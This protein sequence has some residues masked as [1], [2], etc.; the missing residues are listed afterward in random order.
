M[1]GAGGSTLQEQ[2]VLAA[3]RASALDLI[4]VLHNQGVERIVVAAPTTDWLPGDCDVIR[5]NDPPDAPFHFGE[6]LAALIERYELDL[7]TYFGGGSAPLLDASLGE[8]IVG[9]LRGTVDPGSV[10]IPARVVLTNNVHSSDWA[11]ISR[12]RDVLPLIRD[13]R[14]DNSLA[15]LLKE[16]GRYDVRAVSGIRPA[17]SMDIDTPSDLALLARHPALQPRLRQIVNDPRL[18]SIPIDDVLDVMRS[19][20]KTLAIF[21]RVSPQAWVALNRVSRIWTRVVAEERGM[22]AAERIERG[23]VR[24]V[25]VPWI[26]ARGFDGFFADLADMADAALIDSRVIFA[27]SHVYPSA[28]DRFASDLLWT[29]LIRDPWV[30]EFT[31]AAANAGIP[32]ILGGHSMVSG[33]L[34]ALV[35]IIQADSA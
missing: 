3:Q 25:L 9:I 34:H 14:R 7:I 16:S 26:R 30:R 21:G 33:G 27:A 23:E 29:D 24:S 31:R 12:A 8:M 28:A 13:M 6:R 32:V 17:I 19:E 11:A 10:S 2:L 4:A 35:E 15:W 18:R 1:L 5:E 20:A 22:V